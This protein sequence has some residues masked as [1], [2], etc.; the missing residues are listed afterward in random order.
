MSC[1][2][3]PRIIGELSFNLTEKRD[4]RQATNIDTGDNFNDKCILCNSMIVSL[5]IT[6]VIG[7]LWFK[8]NFILREHKLLRGSSIYRCLMN[9]GLA[10][11]VI[12]G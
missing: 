8:G 2:H 12:F 7:E 11:E 5:S 4:P 10:F 3:I 9:R 1:S 6:V